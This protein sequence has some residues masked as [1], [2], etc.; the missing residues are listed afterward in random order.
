MVELYGHTPIVGQHQKRH[1]WSLDL[2]YE[3]S[4]VDSFLNSRNLNQLHSSLTIT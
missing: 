4:H 1:E 3:P 2:S